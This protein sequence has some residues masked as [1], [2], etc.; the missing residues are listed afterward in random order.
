MSAV[1]SGAALI[2]TVFPPK[3]LWS[4]LLNDL[5][6]A[7]YSGYRVALIIGAD[8]STVY[9]WL[10]EGKEPRHSYGAALIEL[11]CLVCGPATSQ[12]RQAEALARV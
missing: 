12:K 3:Y 8:W 4:D 6:D 10:K 7:G 5:R 9:G 1:M 2:K 11:H